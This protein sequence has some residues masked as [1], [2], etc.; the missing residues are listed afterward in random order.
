MRIIKLIQKSGWKINQRVIKKELYSY[1]STYYTM[2]NDKLET[3]LT[4][5]TNEMA[6]LRTIVALTNLILSCLIVGKLFHWI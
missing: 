4:K 1:S 5:H 3:T 2:N 6:F